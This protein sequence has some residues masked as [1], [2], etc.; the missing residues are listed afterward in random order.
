MSN[1]A[2]AAAAAVA[3]A[4]SDPYAWIDELLREAV[5]GIRLAVENGTVDPILDALSSGDDV[6]E[7]LL[8]VRESASACC[9]CHVHVVAT[10]MPDNDLAASF[11]ILSAG[12]FFS[13]SKPIV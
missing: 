6:S 1:K 11:L 8:E 7:M 2:V 4:T 12:F 13:E 9:C 3:A 10:R 5:V